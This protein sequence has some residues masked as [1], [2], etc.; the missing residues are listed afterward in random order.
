[1]SPRRKLW[2]EVRRSAIHGAGAFALRR[3]P[4]GTWIIQYTGE[5]IT[6]DEADLRYDDASM[7][8]HHTF[9]FVLDEQLCIDAAVGGNDARFI[10]HSCAPNCEA[11]HSEADREIWIV[12]QRTIEPGEELTYDYGYQLDGEDLES[13]RR[14]Y[15]CRCGTPACRGT[16][17]AI[18]A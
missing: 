2:F 18:P 17:M 9:L 14:D 10:N 3:I 15:P 11:V 5:I 16:I 1:M 8:Q 6:N 4:R 13:A 12:A 7:A